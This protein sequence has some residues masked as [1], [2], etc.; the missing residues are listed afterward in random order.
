MAAHSD[1]LGVGDAVRRAVGGALDATVG[2]VGERVGETALELSSATARQ[3]IDELEPYLIETTVPRIVDG[4]TPYLVA[5][6]APAIVDGL[7]NYL[8]EVT[9]PRIVDDLAEHLA[10]HT[11][12]TVMAA[13]APQLVAD[14]LPELLDSLRPYLVAELV[15]QIID[16]LTPYINDQ[17]AP[18]VMRE[19][20]PEIRGVIVPQIMDDIIEDPKVREL[21]REQ[22]QGLLFDAVERVRAGLA[23]ADDML[24][25]LVR[26]LFRQTPRTLAEAV[27]PPA[28]PARRVA[29][30]GVVS[31]A[32]STALDL[33]VSAW[34]VG[35]A[36][37]SIVA[38][39]GQL[40]DPMPNWLVVALAL[41][42][43][44]VVPLYFA[45]CWWL[46][47]RTAAEFLVGLR[48]C[49]PSGSRMGPIRAFLRAFLGLPLLVVWTIGM[50]PS[51]FRPRRRGLVE[52]LS[53]TEVR[54]TVH[55]SAVRSR[56]E[57]APQP[58]PQPDSAPME[59]A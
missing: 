7:T 38:V 11:I 5:D 33:T 52:R 26:R 1:P 8:T 3:V 45:L 35:S 42:G 29:N 13:A 58:A 9:V 27:D 31:R 51:F 50:I 4:I 12:P 32:V 36:I 16:G 54:Y 14:V 48:V 37:S 22:S 28:P 10:S 40:V 34:L 25:N 6:A 17:L 15:P 56:V 53:G 19:L 49:L 18:E 41:L 47:G 2:R 21:I 55:P 59:A 20:M 57:R 43:A 24:E 23:R 39:L 46:A 44:A 30:A